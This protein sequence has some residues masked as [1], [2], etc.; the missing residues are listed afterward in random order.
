MAKYSGDGQFYE[1]VVDE[2]QDEDADAPIYVVTFSGYGNQEVLAGDDLRPAPGAAAAVKKKAA[3][4]PLTV[5][6]TPFAQA[7]AAAAAASQQKKRSAGVFETEDFQPST[8]VVVGGGGGATDGDKKKKAKKDG[9]SEKQQEKKQLMERVNGWK[10]FAGKKS[11]VVNKQS[12]FATADDPNYRVGVTGSGK[13][14]GIPW[15][16]PRPSNEKWLVP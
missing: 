12:I 8:K 14:V 15:L 10:Q 1:A 2:I 6:D 3:A 7:S 9:P 11:G 16:L 13:P 4:A 5:A